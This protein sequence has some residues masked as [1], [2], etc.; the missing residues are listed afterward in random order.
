MLLALVSDLREQLGFDDMTDINFAITMALNGAEPQIAA[1]LN[2]DFPQ[3]T[4]T[5]TFYVERPPFQSGGAV[6]TEFR[7]RNGLVSALASVVWN[8]IVTGFSVPA[9][10]VDVTSVVQLHQDKGIVKDFTTRYRRVYVQITYTAGF[11]VDGGNPAS[12]LLSSVPVWLQEAAKLRALLDLA[13]S[14]ALSEA[15]IKL[16]TQLLGAQ[17]Q[18]LL[19]RH[20]RYAPVSV[21]PL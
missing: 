15:N 20:L 8:P 19:S 21:L 1:L 7:L 18:A 13:D 17:F 2:T 11:A 12:Y 10:N 5:D 9:S 6:S 16:D 14:P 4:F 3:G